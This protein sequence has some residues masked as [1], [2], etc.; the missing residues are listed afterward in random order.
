MVDEGSGSGTPA[1]AVIDVVKTYV[2]GSYELLRS[3][4]RI[5]MSA[6]P[7]GPLATVQVYEKDLE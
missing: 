3:F 1:A 7:A 6:F 4:A 5:I 2:F